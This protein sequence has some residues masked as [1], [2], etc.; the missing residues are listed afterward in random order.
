MEKAKIV[1]VPL[2]MWFLR[3]LD[4]VEV[5]AGHVV[6]EEGGLVRGLVRELAL[7]NPILALIVEKILLD[8]FM[9]GTK[10]RFS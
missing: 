10:R 2:I 9:A 8:L 7:T 6:L 5:N 3:Y 1:T 4:V